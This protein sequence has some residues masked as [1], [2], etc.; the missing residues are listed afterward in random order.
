M[1]ISPGGTCPSYLEYI[2]K[3]STPAEKSVWKILPG[4]RY[5]RETGTL[6]FRRKVLPSLSSIFLSSLTHKLT[7]HLVNVVIIMAHTTFTLGFYSCKIVQVCERH[8]LWFGAGFPFFCVVPPL[9]SSKNQGSLIDGKLQSVESS[10]DEIS[11]KERH[12]TT[13]MCIK[14]LHCSLK[15][16]SGFINYLSVKPG[17]KR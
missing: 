12:C 6:E 4:P 15:V 9:S 1:S 14:S 10:T 7:L 16:S 8:V 11:Y 2:Q 3:W 13:Y 5:H 17:K